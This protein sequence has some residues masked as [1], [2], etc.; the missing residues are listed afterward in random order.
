LERR[1][2]KEFTW[3]KKLVFAEAEREVKRGWKKR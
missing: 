2:I 1:D 3:K